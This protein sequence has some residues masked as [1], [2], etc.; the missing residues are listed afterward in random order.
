M[1]VLHG[2]P[3]VD[4]TEPLGVPALA[5]VDLV[6]VTRPDLYCQIGGVGMPPSHPQGLVERW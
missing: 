5:V 6:A 3:I 1:E 2:G 4:R